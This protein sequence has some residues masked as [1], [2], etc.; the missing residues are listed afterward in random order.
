MPRPR[1][2]AL[3]L[4]AA[5]AGPAAADNRYQQLTRQFAN[6]ADQAKVVAAGPLGGAG[7]EWLAGGGFQPDGTVVVAGTSLGPTLDLGGVAATV[8]GKDAPAPAA[9]APK[10]KVDGKGK[11]ELNKD[12]TP[13]F[14]DVG[15][16]DP[17]ATAFVARLSADL[18]TVKGVARFPWKAGG[19]TAAAVADDGSV[20]LAGPAGDGIAGVGGDVQEQKASD[21]GPA[22]AA[23]G[24]TYL[25][26]IDAGGTKVLWVRHVKAPSNAP[27]VSLG[28]DGTVRFQGPDIRTF[29]AAGKQLTVTVVP[30]ALGRTTAVSPKDGTFARGGETRN[31]GTGR[32][33][34]RDPFLYVHEP[35]GKLK[36]ELYHWDGPLIGL[37]N[38]RLVSDSVVRLVKYDADG[39]LILYAW[40]DG[41]NSVM[42][43]EPFDVR[44]EAKAFKGLGMSAWGAG[45]LSCA[46]V[47]KLDPKDYRVVGG[48]LWLA[49]LNDK[50]KP[51]SIWIDSLGFAADGSVCVGGKSAWG[52][53]ET[54]NKLNPGEPTGPYVSVFNKDYTS[55]RFSSTLP[56]TGTADVGEGGRWAF[57]AGKG[58]VLCLGSTTGK[59]PKGTAAPTAGGL[60]PAFGGGA[61]DGYLLLL[62]LGK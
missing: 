54:A 60:K 47:I 50:D 45:V 8:I 56:A 6:T 3:G 10:P 36:Y 55:L 38:L 23:V 15:W 26:R 31:W 28:A 33:P 57:A 35:A 53:V 40:S 1:A 9:Y 30:T 4:L 12:G 11:P 29:D 51:N 17:A 19:V 24:H 37:D 39:N 14:D 42:Y 41:G 34:Y 44:R 13:K 20:Y 46:Y 61:S 49:Y 25:A 43:R 16:T 59:D 58:R 22:K 52:L 62:D 32:E 18:K 7:T 27:D 21:G 5:L 48:T 2:L